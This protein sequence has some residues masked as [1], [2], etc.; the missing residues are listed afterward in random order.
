MEHRTHS[1]DTCWVVVQ[2]R[3]T[4]NT[5]IVPV[6]VITIGNHYR[7]AVAR[8]RGG[9]PNHD[10]VRVR[11]HRHCLVKQRDMVDGSVV[12]CWPLRNEVVLVEKT[13]ASS[14]IYVALRVFSS[15]SL[16]PTATDSSPL[17]TVIPGYLVLVHFRPSTR[18]EI[19]VNGPPPIVGL[20]S[21]QSQV[22][23]VKL[24]QS[25]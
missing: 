23:V 17:V 4:G 6:Y 14:Q 21:L 19:H 20:A 7:R 2:G 22:S 18:V 3:Q 11:H 9:M 13:D 24:K 25:M 16:K 8:G 10:R 1:H 5:A 15:R 12:S